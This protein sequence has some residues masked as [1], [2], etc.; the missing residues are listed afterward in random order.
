RRPTRAQASAALYQRNLCEMYRLADRLDEALESGRRL[1][2]LKPD[3]VTGHHFLSMIHYGR[4]EP[5]Q[6]AVPARRAVE[7]DP[8]HAGAHFELAESLLVRGDFIPEWAEYEVRHQL[9]T[10]KP[11]L[12]PAPLQPL[13]DG[14][15]HGGPVLL[16]A[17]QGFGDVI[18]FCRYIPMVAE[19]LTDFAVACNPE[20]TWI[21][22]Q[23]PGVQRIIVAPQGVPA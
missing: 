15:A 11:R 6:A 8:Q 7:L 10:V 18:Q 14:R 19:R 4:C 1:L 16:V 21:I 2:A 9:T 17:D 13:W 20:V 5:D 3:D 12:S 22:R 23:Q